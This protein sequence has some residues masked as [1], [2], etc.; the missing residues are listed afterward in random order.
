MPRGIYELAYPW[1]T[2]DEPEELSPKC[3]VGFDFNESLP[4]TSE[5]RT[6]TIDIRSGILGELGRLVGNES[7]LTPELSTTGIETG[8][9][10][11][12]AL[13]EELIECDFTCDA[14]YP[15]P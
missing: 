13:Q 6:S 15:Y 1:I 5:I 12:V 2:C 7:L 10:R 9:C 8:I 14:T 4:H 11:A 3:T